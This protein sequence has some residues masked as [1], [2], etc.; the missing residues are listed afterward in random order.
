MRSTGRCMLIVASVL[1]QG[2]AACGAGEPA[3]PVDPA[4]VISS[5]EPLMAAHDYNAARRRLL[6]AWESS[7]RNALLATRLAECELL[8]ERAPQ[9][10]GRLEVA[11]VWNEDDARLLLWLAAAAKAAGRDGQAADALERALAAAGEDEV[12][13][14]DL[15]EELLRRGVP[16]AAAA[17]YEKILS[18]YPKDSQFDIFS[19][20]QLAVLHFASGRNSEA[21]R[22][23]QRAARP[24]EFGDVSILTPQETR[25]WSAIFE[26]LA[27][28]D[29]G[30]LEDG[31]RRLRNAAAEFPPGVAADA[32]LVE[33][34]DKAGRTDEASGVFAL[35]AR[36]L[37]G[38]V[39]AEPEN[40]RL[41]HEMALLSAL[42]GRELEEGLR[43]CQ[44]A[45]TQKPLMAEFMDTKAALLIRLGRHE[46]AL[47]SS[48]RAM[49]LA[50][51]TRWAPP[52]IS[53][54]FA[55]RR[56][57]ALEGTGVPVPAAFRELP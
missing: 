53:M 42:S 21:A 46:E 14:Y 24:M 34:L 54:T 22:A 49:A 27:R 35:S 4:A 43:Y 52:A 44:W 57:E 48:E 39:N 12:A 33:Q 9:A 28:I 20:L 5:A 26:A 16:S 25:Y 6:E 3:A 50:T 15:A 38:A 40:A 30:A 13:L 55:L 36:R 23:M 8:S 2:C 31:L 7:S 19:C 11:L 37:E 10:A 32:I 1:V 29:A 17:I 41:Y 18:V 51:A 47:R 56:L 45:L